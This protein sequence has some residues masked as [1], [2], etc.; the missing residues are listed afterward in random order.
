M[1]LFVVVIGTIFQLGLA[2]VLF[3]FFVMGA[4]AGNNGV[5]TIGIFGAP[6]SCLIS[7]GLVIHSYKVGGSSSI[8]WWYTMPLIL[9]VFLF[10]LAVKLK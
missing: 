2:G 4:G 10:V 3:M 6:I 1:S 9:T 5:L 7:I 8:Y